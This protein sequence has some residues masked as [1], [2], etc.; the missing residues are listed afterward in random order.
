MSEFHL[1]KNVLNG[2]LKV[3]LPPAKLRNLA[4]PVEARAIEA[5]FELIIGNHI[6]AD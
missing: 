2:T 5:V 1:V 4:V 3:G 6:S